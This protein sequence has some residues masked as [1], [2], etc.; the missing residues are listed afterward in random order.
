MLY[1][2]P[3]TNRAAFALSLPAILAVLGA[4]YLTTHD[5][6]PEE[7]LIATSTLYGLYAAGFIGWIL[8]SAVVSRET[9]FGIAIVLVITV[10]LPALFGV[11]GAVIGVYVFFVLGI[12]AV[13]AFAASITLRERESSSAE[14]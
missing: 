8:L 6:T 14:H 7:A 10:T 12:P 11:Y 13:G 2:R 4:W 9:L 3:M 1:D 5:N